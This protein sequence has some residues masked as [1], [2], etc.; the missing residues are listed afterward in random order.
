MEKPNAETTAFYN[1]LVPEDF[2]V[3]KGQMFGHP[4]AFVFGN[5]FLGTFGQSV[6]MRLGEARAAALAVPPV[7]IFEPMAGRPWREYIQLS[8]GMLPAETL[9]ALAAEALGHTA[10]LPPKAPKVAKEPKAKAV[11]EPKA[12][13]TKAQKSE[14]SG[15]P[16]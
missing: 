9:A 12:K 13:A 15:P 14:G 5:M 1:R 3:I 6:L 8:E 11:K 2:R 16:G 7:A 4:C 10:G